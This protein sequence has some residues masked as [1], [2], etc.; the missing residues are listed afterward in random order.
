MKPLATL[1]DLQKGW[2]DL[3][4]D[5]AL[6]AST[7][8]DRASAQLYTLLG[9]ANIAVDPANELQ[10]IN[11]CTVT[12]NMVRRVLGGA[13]N[14]SQISQTIGSTTASLSFSNPDGSLYLSKADKELLG[15]IGKNRYRTV[16]AHTWAD[17][18]C[19]DWWWKTPC[20]SLAQCH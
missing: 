16:Q 13:D 9:R 5:E 3:T 4:D 18:C 1:A 17:E 6:E 12:C 19:C 10:M 11:L 15:L 20:L 7:L 8:I 2:R 14:V